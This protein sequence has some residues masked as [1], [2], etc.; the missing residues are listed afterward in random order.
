MAPHRVV[1]AIVEPRHPGQAGDFGEHV[2]Q[3]VSIRVGRSATKV[4]RL[5]VGGARVA[6]TRSGNQR[7][8]DQAV[9]F[10]EA[11]EYAAEQPRDRGLGQCTGAPDPERVAGAFGVPRGSVLRFQGGFHL[12]N[13][14]GALGE[15]LFK[16]PQ[17]PS[18]IGEESLSVDHGSAGCLP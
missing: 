13:A 18:Q 1:L 3:V 14:L 6:F 16:P 10:H 4:E 7:D 11:H 2:E 5:P 17:L 8:V 12:R 15:I 9:V